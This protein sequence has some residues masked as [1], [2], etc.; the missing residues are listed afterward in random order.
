MPVTACALRVSQVSVLPSKSE[1]ARSPFC[2]AMFH[3]RRLCLAPAVQGQGSNAGATKS[4][5][6]GRRGRLCALLRVLQQKRWTA[7]GRTRRVYTNQTMTS[8]AMNFANFYVQ[9][10]VFAVLASVRCV[11]FSATSIYFTLSPYNGEVVQKL[12]NHERVDGRPA[13]AR[14]P[15]TWRAK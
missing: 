11:I 2:L 5:G 14:N 8:V 13:A 7:W 4:R 1:G 12:S 3:P 15:D 10:N 9:L 6:A